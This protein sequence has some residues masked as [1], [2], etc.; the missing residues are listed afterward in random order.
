MPNPPIALAA[1]AL[2]AGVSAAAAQPVFPPGSSLG[3]QPPPG[4]APSERFIGFEGPNRASIEFSELHGTDL[5]TLR[6]ELTPQGA[7]RAGL[8]ERERRNFLLD[9]GEIA[10][11]IHG[12]FRTQ[13]G[14][15]R[16][17]FMHWD[18]MAQSA[19]R[20]GRVRVQ[21]PQADITPRLQNAIERSLAGLVMRP[22]DPVALRA[23]LPFSFSETER[24]R[25]ANV[26][27]GSAAFLAPPGVMVGDVAALREPQMAI[28]VSTQTQAVPPGREA[29]M[30]RAM[31][32]QMT[33]QPVGPAD[34][35]QARDVAGL[36][37]SFV[38]AESTYG[39][40]QVPTRF[41]LWLAVLPDGRTL[42]VIA[43]APRERFG[44]TWPDF[45]SVL[46]SIA[47]R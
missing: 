14:Q 32:Q 40:E 10:L 18:L 11:L 20:V 34:P 7:A 1:L 26:A 2:V 33:R 35:G 29:G 4:F 27:G 46:G 41:G 19:G 13:V 23:A 21:V 44:A 3:L 16:V 28:G 12:E 38:Q 5:A 22:P 8:T 31:L 37:A 36:K 6:R 47:L 30:A 24:L 43:Q 9:S 17:T 25:L 39:P 15:S 45:E 42:T